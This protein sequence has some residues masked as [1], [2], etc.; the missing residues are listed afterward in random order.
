MKKASW[1]QSLDSNSSSSN[2]I[3][4]ILKDVDSY[5]QKLRLRVLENSSKVLITGDLNSG[6]STL[7]NAIL[8]QN[9]LPTDQQPCTQLF[10][11]V[12][13]T[14]ESLTKIEAYKNIPPLSDAHADEL[15][16][17]Q[18]NKELQS[19][20]SVYKW[21]K[22][23]VPLP[24]DMSRHR[25]PITISLIDSPGLNTDL[26]KTTSLFDQQQDIDVIVFVVN[27]S[28]HLTLSGKEFLYQAAKE[29]EKI[30]FVVNK[31]D[32]IENHLKCRNVITNQIREILPETFQDAQTLIHF[33]SAKQ[34]LAGLSENDYLPSTEIEV[35]EEVQNSKKGKAQME[36]TNDFNN[37]KQS[38]LNF[39][40]LKRSISKLAPAKTFCTRLLQD[41]LE[42]S[43]FNF[44]QMTSESRKF[45]SKLENYIETI[46]KLDKNGTNL[47]SELQ[48]IVLKSSDECY[49]SVF[50]TTS[51]FSDEIPK[52]INCHKTPGI[53]NLRINVNSRYKSVAAN[54]S[55]T[56]SQIEKIIHDQKRKG[57]NYIDATSDAYGIKYNDSD[58]LTVQEFQLYSSMPLHKPS[59]LE[60]LYPQDLFRNIGTLNLTSI[61][62]AVFG[63]QPCLNFGWSFARRIGLN[64]LLMSAIIVGGLGKLNKNNISFYFIICRCFY[65]LYGGF[66]NRKRGILST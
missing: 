65:N 34:H 61:F 49:N 57:L 18:M 40:Y 12:I 55:K 14:D 48:N 46:Q 1:L 42:L 30:F 32:E 66:F 4:N 45:E 38:L 31:F 11:E 7:I 36:S 35:N 59:I 33:V 28:F 3:I 54:Y 60:L 47:K 41:L 20:D 19:E 24:L 53:W 44:R 17:A 21:F 6:K 2:I 37:M 51:A 39:I 15:S 23:Y 63:F 29:K 13:P 5:L 58:N 26:F 50:E 62:G 8:Q 27:A 10:C 56:I 43:S 16:H 9:I 52:S 64:P 25:N 22:I